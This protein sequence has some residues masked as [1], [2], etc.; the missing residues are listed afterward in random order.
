MIVLKSSV[1]AAA[2]S[3]GAHDAPNNALRDLVD[4]NCA[5]ELLHVSPRTLDRWHLLRTGPPRA[6]IGG[7]VRYR[8][9]AISNWLDSCETVG[10]SKS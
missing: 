10:P 9:S 8:L 7:L 6:K 3:G 5:A 2:L 1:P 4:R